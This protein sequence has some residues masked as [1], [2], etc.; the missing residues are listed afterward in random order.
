ML[1]VDG[2]VL[3][4]LQPPAR[5][6]LFFHTLLIKHTP[7]SQPRQQSVFQADERINIEDERVSI[8][9]ERFNIEDYLHKTKN[10][11]VDDKQPHF[12]G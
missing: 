9:D 10:Y 11:S 4:L 7:L 1:C 5:G 2:K 12:K 8:E 6:D 3:R